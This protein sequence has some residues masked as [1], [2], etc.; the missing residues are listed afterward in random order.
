MCVATR[1][2]HGAADRCDRIVRDRTRVAS[3]TKQQLHDAN[4]RITRLI[5]E[6]RYA[7]TQLSDSLN[8]T[9][10]QELDSL[11]QDHLQQTEA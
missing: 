6:N 5:E 2:L 11:V 9:H 8:E 7:L 3:Q 10:K 1:T 4:A